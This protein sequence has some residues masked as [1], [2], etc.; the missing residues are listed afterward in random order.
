MNRTLLYL[1]TLVSCTLFAGTE[2]KKPLTPQEEAIQKQLI[3]EFG[4]FGK[5]YKNASSY[6]SYTLNQ[7]K[8]SKKELKNKKVQYEGMYL[9][10]N[11]N[12]PQYIEDSGYSSKRYYYFIVDSMDIPVIA[13]RS[14][15]VTN[16]LGKLKRGAKLRIYGRLKE[17]KSKN[18]HGMLP[19]YFIDLASVTVLSNEETK[20]GNKAENQQPGDKRGPRRQWKR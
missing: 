2:P 17:F 20:D 12:F 14:K 19:D 18:R 6:K 4:E 5:E 15:D 11:D 7:L 1:M 10:F 3:E 8:L 13:R 9:Q 16:L